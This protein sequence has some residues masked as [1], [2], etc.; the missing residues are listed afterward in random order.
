MPS[1]PKFLRRLLP[2]RKIY[3]T[4]QPGKNFHVINFTISAAPEHN[5]DGEMMIEDS[6]GEYRMARMT[7]DLCNLDE[8]IALYG[9]PSENGWG[10]EADDWEEA[11]TTAGGAGVVGTGVAAG[12]ASAAAAG[13]AT[14]A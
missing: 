3:P 2:K 7:V 6:T 8:Y 14:T 11:V 4:P 10:E 9:Q 13:G 5:G 12:P 1:L